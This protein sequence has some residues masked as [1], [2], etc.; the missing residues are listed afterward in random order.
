MRFWPDDLLFDDQWYLHN[1]EERRAGRSLQSSCDL[2]V[3]ASWQQAITGTGVIIGIV[4][5]GVD[6]LH[7]DL[8][9][10]YRA[11]LGIDLV[12]GDNNPMA[13]SDHG[14]LHGTS[15]AGIAAGRGNNGMGITGVAPTASFTAI[16]LTSGCVSDRQEAQVMNHR[17]QSIAIYNNSWGPMD[18][19]GLTAPGPLFQAAL[20]RG[21]QQGR[22]GLGSLYVWAGGNGRREGD[23]VNYDGYANSRY[24][25]AVAAINA[26]GQQTEYS[27]SGACLLVS[28]FGDDGYDQG[29]TST[30]L[31][32]S[33]GYNFNGLGIYGANYSDLNYT[34]D[35]GGTSAAAPMV[36]G[37]LAL[38]L[39]ANPNLSW[40][41]AQH[42]LVETARHNDPSNTDWQRNGA[43]R[44]VNHSYGFGAVNATAAVNLARTWQPVASERSSVVSPV[45]VR[46]SIPEQRQGA[47]ST[48]LME[49]NLQI[50]RVEV[51]FNATHTR[52]SDLR[53]VLTS[54]DG[55]ASVLAKTNRMAHF[56][57]YRNWVFTSTRL[58]D[59]W[60]AGN[61]T[62]TVSDGRTGQ[63]GV[64]N[65]W[66]LRVYGIGQGESTVVDNRQATYR[67]DTLTSRG[68]HHVL[69]G[70]GGD[71]RL[72][73]GAGSD[74]LMGG[75]GADLLRGDYGSDRLVGSYGNDVLLGGNGT[76]HLRGQQGQDWLR[77]GKD[78]DQLWGGAGVDTFVL[79]AGNMGT[80]DRIW[81]FQ[82]GVDCIKVGSTLQGG[83][84]SWQQKGNNTLLKVGQQALAW[85][86]DVNASQLSGTELA[87]A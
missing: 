63:S 56:G 73:G 55:T 57:S 70:F 5:D 15:V 11:D 2:N 61:W 30:D 74:Y 80:V 42:I 10:N 69:K 45:Q 84:L 50:E 3:L 75:N 18:G 72:L 83:P 58:W 40:R 71:D 34:N 44:W 7:P 12:D 51:V 19:Y 62:L 26:Q 28:A 23:N 87:L 52:S 25:I 24:V 6:Y 79:D 33:E 17:F 16:R 67:Q 31:R 60:S 41:D 43:G 46:A 21:V 54:P 14:D 22:N 20:A 64:W 39:Q 13:E 78:R 49:D 27:E 4:D 37:V 66:Q 1:T 86:M 35:F 53:I 8:R 38:M 76:D 29:I 77:G 59:E 32:R 82:A 47:R 9:A 36:S 85:L 81:D 68:D 65:S 48:I